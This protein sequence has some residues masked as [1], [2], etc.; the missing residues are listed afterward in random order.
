MAIG[1]LF[2]VVSVAVRASG[3]FLR[4][5]FADI[6]ARVRHFAGQAERDARIEI[7]AEISDISGDIGKLTKKLKGIKPLKVAATV[8]I[9]DIPDID[10]KT[11]K[12]KAESSGFK[13]LRET[14]GRRGKE[15]GALLG[16]GVKGGFVAGLIGL[17]ALIAAPVAVVVSGV[18]RR[19]QEGLQLANLTALL[20]DYTEEISALQGAARLLGIP[21]DT[22]NSGLV[23]MVRFLGEVAEG[24]EGAE[25]V[26]ESLGL[27]WADLAKKSPVEA[28]KDIADAINKYR[29]EEGKLSK[30]GIIDR[31][32][33]EDNTEQ[34]IGRLIKEGSDGIK[35]LME[36]ARELG[37]VM[38]QETLEATLKLATE[39]AALQLAM[40]GAQNQLVDELMPDLLD[41][42]RVLREDVIPAV[43]D[44]D[45]AFRLTMR[46]IIGLFRGDVQPL[47][48]Q[49]IRTF[50]GMW[51]G[52]IGAAEGGVNL[53]NKL[54]A[55]TING[56]AILLE[57]FFG[58]VADMLSKLSFTV[59]GVT[60]GVPDGVI[61]ALRAGLGRVEAGNIEFGRLNTAELLAQYRTERG[62]NLQTGRQQTAA[63]RVALTRP[64]AGVGLNALAT[65]LP[66]VG[67]TDRVVRVVNVTQYGDNYGMDDF[68][69]A[70]RA[71]IHDGDKRGVVE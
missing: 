53:L 69:E 70:A 55:G 19:I 50:A 57:K 71:A 3:K 11:V 49:A 33:G 36:R 34:G 31:I 46:S 28:F 47:A 10:D 64:E 54:A 66:S 65:D 63:D 14:F 29:D 37:V 42:A 6:R 39:M 35:E 23:D 30:Q 58:K 4:G 5:D 43:T 17:G 67:Y 32:F 38:D 21:I 25:D 9:P 18:T 59:G 27:N 52:I 61:S 15:L 62:R 1:G 40:E 26:L 7:K 12:I 51:N 56:N 2:G 22:V 60:F 13:R 48:E 8:D 41:L 24:D 20:G 44:T 16:A 45:G 68:N